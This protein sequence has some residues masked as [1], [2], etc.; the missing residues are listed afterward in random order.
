MESA[1]LACREF[2]HPHTGARIKELLQKIFN[3][4][5]LDLENVIRFTSDK[6][7]N[8]VLGLKPFLVAQTA[9]QIA[10]LDDVDPGDGRAVPSLMQP[11]T[12]FSL[13]EGFIDIELDFVMDDEDDSGA[14]SDLEDEDRDEDET[15]FQ[16]LPSAPTTSAPPC[17]A[18]TASATNLCLKR[19]K[20]ICFMKQR[21]FTR[22]TFPRG[23]L[24]LHMLSI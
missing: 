15:S 13:P 16:P 18:S 9:P 21:S 14:G 4:Q 19:P 23:S 2:T 22:K 12:S 8:V 1:D 5:S 24:A 10:S 6:G 20:R 7:S 11:S 3:D 17:Q